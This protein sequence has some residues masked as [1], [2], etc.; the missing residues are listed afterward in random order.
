MKY[1]LRA[2][3]AGLGYLAGGLSGA[4][5]GWDYGGAASRFLG[6][7]DYL[8][9]NQIVDGPV[10]GNPQQ[11]IHHAMTAQSDLSGDVI[12][13]NTEFVKNI[14]APIGASGVSTFNIESFDLNPGLQSIFPFLSQIAQN[15]ELYEFMGLMFQYKPTSGEFGNTTSNALG[16]VILATNYD[17]DAPVFSNSI[18][19]ENYD[20]ACSTK[21]SN[22][23]I[24]GVECHPAQ[25]SVLQMYTRTGE[26][27]LGS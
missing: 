20:Y 18:V 9:T 6:Y 13:S 1:G 14:Y 25:R 27:T 11:N 3:G 16:K 23:C 5:S 24:H 19:M 22:G 12:Y 10:H 21:P 2:G 7:G 17:P 8:S 4:K 26:S 15:F